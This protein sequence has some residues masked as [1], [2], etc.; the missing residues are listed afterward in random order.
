MIINTEFKGTRISDDALEQKCLWL[1]EEM[2]MADRV[3]YSCF[4][5]YS[6]MRVKRHDRALRTG[7]LRLPLERRDR[8][9]LIDPWQLA[10]S[11]GIDAIHPHFSQLQIPG[12]LEKAH[13]MGLAVNTWTVD[14][15]ADIRAS[16]LAGADGIIGDRPDLMVKVRHELEEANS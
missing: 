7:L 14:T 4:N 2:G 15:E 1:A 6:L 12:Q 10:S 3:L 8:E 13:A 9:R 11:M 16:L 5:H